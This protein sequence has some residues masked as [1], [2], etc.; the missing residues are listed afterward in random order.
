GVPSSIA[1]AMGSVMNI[2]VLKS[3]FYRIASLDTIGVIITALVAAGLF[4]LFTGAPLIIGFL[5]LE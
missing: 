3:S 4:S 1:L 5:F 2:K